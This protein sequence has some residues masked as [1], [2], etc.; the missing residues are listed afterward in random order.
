MR[1]ASDRT[2]PRSCEMNSIDT[3]VR[4][5]RSRSSSS[6]W[7]CTETSSADSTSSQSSSD[8]PAISARAI[9]TRWRSPPDSSFGKRSR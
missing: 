4:W 2:T 3:P 8:G 1:S 7:A 6:T 5:R 9:A